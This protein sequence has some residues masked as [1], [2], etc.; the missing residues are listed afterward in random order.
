MP[1]PK[2]SDQAEAYAAIAV[3]EP[4][5]PAPPRR[6]AFIVRVSRRLW[7]LAADRRHRGVM[8]LVWRRPTHAFQPFNETQPDRYPGIFRFVQKALGAQ[9]ELRILSFGCSTGEEVF[10]LRSY[11]PRAAIKGID[12]NPGNIALARRRLKRSGDATLSFAVA[13]STAAEPDG[14]YDAIF[15]MAVLRHGNLGSPAIARCDHLIRFADFAAAVADFSRCLKR[16]GF[17]VIR[18]SNFRLCDAPTGAGFESILSVKLPQRGAKT[19]LFGPDNL[20]LETTEYP[21]TVFR[22]K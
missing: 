19:P 2:A 18:H 14:A 4:G 8:W 5:P 21:D 13:G 22:K 1:G 3:T 17:L 20:L 6:P 7:R 12:I 11:F 9:S 15:A 10:S 16:G